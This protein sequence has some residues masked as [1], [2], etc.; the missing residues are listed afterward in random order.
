MHFG[1]KN[2]LKAVGASPR[3]NGD[4]SGGGQGLCLHV[5]R[6]VPPCRVHR[7][8]ISG[9]GFPAP[10]LGPVALPPLSPSSSWGLFPSSLRR[11]RPV[12]PRPGINM[13]S[14]QPKAIKYLIELFL[15][16]DI[17]TRVVICLFIWPLRNRSWVKHL[18]VRVMVVTTWRHC[19]PS[20]RVWVG[21][22]ERG[23][24]VSL[25]GE[26]PAGGW[27]EQYSF[28][29]WLSPEGCREG[30]GMWARTAFEVDNRAQ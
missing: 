11:P 6:A 16:G 5:T 1:T 24:C 9:P 29:F 13:A 15:C 20:S 7:L 4:F 14:K 28:S 27:E 23:T 18:K 17:V 19:F 2:A 22:G 30:A 12:P 10:G 8:P 26:G 21:D 3:A 25:M